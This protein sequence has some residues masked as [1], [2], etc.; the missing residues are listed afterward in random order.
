[1][2]VSLGNEDARV[3]LA[4]FVSFARKIIVI[5]STKEESLST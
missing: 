5:M 2:P 3:T 4:F 1:M